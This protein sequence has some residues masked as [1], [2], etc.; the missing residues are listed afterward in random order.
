M[1]TLLS[2]SLPTIV[3]E[4]GASQYQYTWVAVAYMLTQTA[5]QPLYGKFSDLIG[6]K[7]GKLFFFPKKARS[8]RFVLNTAVPGGP[9]HEHVCLLHRF[10]IMWHIKGELTHIASC[11]IISFIIVQ[12]ITWLILARALSGVGGGGIVSSVWTIT[13]EI[14]PVHKRA[15]W[16]QALSVESCLLWHTNSETE[17]SY[18]SSPGHLPQSPVPCWVGCSV[19]RNSIIGPN[20]MD[21]SDNRPDN[22]GS[23]FNWRWSCMC[24]FR[25]FVT[26]WVLIHDSCFTVYMNLP[27][28]LVASIV[29]VISLR[30][31][32]L[33][34]RSDASWRE[35]ATKFDFVGL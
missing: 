1:Q 8:G 34:R 15:H 21:L 23:A 12:S 7:V 25:S 11:L 19:V 9:L 5:G 35:L 3:S 30:N 10:S 22:T 27:I 28:C 32:N 6:R 18:C 2:T 31:V 20:G 4:L 29:L 16:S 13:S 17:P 14:V 26:L 33:D 24:R